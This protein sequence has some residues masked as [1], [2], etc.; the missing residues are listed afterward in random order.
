MPS[1]KMDAG[2]A[3]MMERVGNDVHALGVPVCLLRSMYEIAFIDGELSEA[4]SFSPRV[5]RIIDLAAER[6]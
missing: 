2:F 1:P 4:E 5:D 6:V 3:E